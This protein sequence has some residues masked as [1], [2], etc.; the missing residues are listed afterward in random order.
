M[1]RF[2]QR[3]LCGTATPGRRVL[4]RQL[5]LCGQERKRRMV[6]TE[7]IY[8]QP[9]ISTAMGADWLKAEWQFPVFGR[10]GA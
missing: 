10:L 3:R 1:Q 7:A 4:C 9:L 5:Q 8:K 2:R 6:E